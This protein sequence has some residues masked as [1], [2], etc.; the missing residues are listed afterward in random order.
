MALTIWFIAWAEMNDSRASSA[1]D[2]PGLRS[3][4]LSAAYC[5]VVRPI[6]IVASSR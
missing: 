3:S 1:D 2:R 4:E 5:G 6:S